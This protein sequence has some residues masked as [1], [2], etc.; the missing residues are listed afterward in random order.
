LVTSKRKN[1]SIN[2]PNAEHY[3]D[4][5]GKRAIDAENFLRKQRFE[6]SLPNLFFGA[7]PQVSG[8]NKSPINAKKIISK[9]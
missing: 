1:D 7:Q 9:Q 6:L 3:S 4:S 8:K 2:I 5:D